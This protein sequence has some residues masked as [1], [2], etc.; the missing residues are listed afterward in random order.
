MS[1]QTKLSH[2]EGLKG[3]SSTF[4]DYAVRLATS[5]VLGEVAPC[6]GSRS[7]NFLSTW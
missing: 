7:S 3:G 1:R 5:R 2:Q 6:I 4:F